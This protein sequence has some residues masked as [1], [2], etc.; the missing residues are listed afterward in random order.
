MI[1]SG[2]TAIG[3]ELTAAEELIGFHKLA[4]WDLEALRVRSLPERFPEACRKNF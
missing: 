1:A 2:G 3:G 4:G